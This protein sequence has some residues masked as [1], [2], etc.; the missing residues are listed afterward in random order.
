MAEYEYQINRWQN[1]SSTHPTRRKL[2]T[3]S[4]IV[5]GDETILPSGTEIVANVE[6][7]DDN[8]QITGTAFNANNMN[9]LESRINGAF[10]KCLGFVDCGAIDNDD[11]N[12][13]NGF[14]F[15]SAISAQI[16]QCPILEF[17]YSNG[18]NDDGTVCAKTFI[19]DYSSTHRI[20]FDQ[21]SC[22]SGAND[23]TF[24]LKT[25][26]LEL[27]VSNGGVNIRRIQDSSKRLVGANNTTVTSFTVERC[28]SS[29][30]DR[31]DIHINKIIGYKFITT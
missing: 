11:I 21:I 10:E 15:S 13:S 14:N 4:D 17:Y 1:R 28:D 22:G 23:N 20:S 24:Y 19:D 25:A 16:V 8:V 26:V 9:G 29:Y 3:V 5:S 27:T 30:P 7:A 6:R 31:I 12:S 2:T 18:N